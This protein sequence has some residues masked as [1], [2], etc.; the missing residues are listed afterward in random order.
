MSI[1]KI[2]AMLLALLLVFC[3]VPAC[4]F[5]TAAS[6]PS[7]PGTTV[8]PSEPGTT[9]GETEEPKEPAEGKEDA[10]DEGGEIPK[11]SDFYVAAWYAY[12]YGD[13]ILGCTVDGVELDNAEDFDEDSPIVMAKPGVTVSVEVSLKDGYELW[14]DEEDD[15]YFRWEYYSL[16][17]RYG[18]SCVAGSSA[19]QVTLPG[20]DIL[21]DY[22]LLILFFATDYKLTA[23][24]SV[25]LNA[26]VIKEGEGYAYDS[27]EDDC[28]PY[29]EVTVS[30]DAP[31]EVIY[32]GW[33]V[34]SDDPDD[35]YG[36]GFC[37]PEDEVTFEKGQD[38]YIFVELFATDIY[39][40][41]GDETDRAE[42]AAEATRAI[43][44]NGLRLFSVDNPPK[45]TVKNGELV[46][47][48]IPYEQPKSETRMI[49]GPASGEM[50][51][52]LKVHVPEEEEELPPTSDMNPTPWVWTMVLTLSAVLTALYY[53]MEDIKR[54]Y[55]K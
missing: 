29:P 6:D 33:V 24:D 32:A 7:E 10:E 23:I 53:E 1:K 45:I 46:D 39:D 13:D 36:M 42:G 8:D 4:V 34:P 22:P 55:N 44:A 19:T 52:V 18:G 14:Y 51:V 49:S 21:A 31:Y 41:Y 17:G 11:V 43:T 12:S 15:A 2:T 47:F 38:Y 37:W 54:A 26:P 28:L 30:L 16:E 40:V 3:L 27:E 5:A 48:Y 50:L 20:E 9:A 35:L 25:T